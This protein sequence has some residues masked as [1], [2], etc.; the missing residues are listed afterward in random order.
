MNAY[1]VAGKVFLQVTTLRVR[2]RLV[3]ML[4]CRYILFRP[5]TLE[6]ISEINFIG[7]LPL[8]LANPRNLTRPGA[9]LVY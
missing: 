9:P 6:D 1:L 3:E 7:P 2:W 4:A 8:P 5:M